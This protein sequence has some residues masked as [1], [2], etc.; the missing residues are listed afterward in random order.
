ML[1][2]NEG[3]ITDND[4]IKAQ[5]A[6]YITQRLQLSAEE[7]THF[8]SNFNDYEAEREALEQAYEAKVMRQANN[9]AEASA[10]IMARF[11]LDEDLLALK[12]RFY[13]RVKVH[14][15]STKLVLLP[16]IEREFKKS[17]LQRLNQRQQ[18]GRPFNRGGG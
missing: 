4:Q 1:A 16:Q 12:R 15:P 5:R 11:Q 6:A 18:Q 14:V 13:D 2:Q 17:L 9:E 3:R 10:Q 7:A 8:W